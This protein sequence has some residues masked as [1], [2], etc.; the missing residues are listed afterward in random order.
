MKWSRCLLLLLLLVR[1]TLT[2][3]P[4]DVISCHLHSKTA[5]ICGTAARMVL[6]SGAAQLQQC[7]SAVSVNGECSEQ[8]PL[9]V[10]P[11]HCSPADI[12]VVPIVLLQ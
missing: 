9:A 11:K 6:L 10:E 5:L 8:C 3:P 2:P 4:D 7:D 12:S 1:V